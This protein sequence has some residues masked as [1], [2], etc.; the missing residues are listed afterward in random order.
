M[1]QV[2]EDID[3]LKNCKDDDE[4]RIIIFKK[5]VKIYTSEA[6]FSQISEKIRSSKFYDI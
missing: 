1:I 2:Y 5:L 3:N 4:T 6:C